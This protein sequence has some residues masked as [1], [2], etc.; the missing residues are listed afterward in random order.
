M[1]EELKIKKRIRETSKKYHKWRVGYRKRNQE[2][3]NKKQLERRRISSLTLKEKFGGKCQICGYDEEIRILEF[4]HI[5]GK[6]FEIGNH[7]HLEIN[8]LIDEAKKCI[9]IC[10]NCHRKIHLKP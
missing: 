2:I 3:I 1:T 5:N 7:Y 9:L 6:N 10:P 4:H 8:K